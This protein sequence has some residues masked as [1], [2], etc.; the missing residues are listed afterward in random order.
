MPVNSILQR[1][2]VVQTPMTV[3]PTANTI[4]ATNIQHNELVGGSTLIENSQSCLTNAARPTVLGAIIRVI[5][6][7]DIP[8]HTTVT[9]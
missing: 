5:V 7:D 1:Y 9:G 4:I 2:V 8:E 6:M 3:S